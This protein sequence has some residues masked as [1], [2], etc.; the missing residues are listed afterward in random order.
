MLCVTLLSALLFPPLNPQLPWFL[1][2]KGLE[3]F[4]DTFFGLGA[5]APNC[6]PQV[7]STP[8]LKVAVQD[9]KKVQTKPALT[10]T[11]FQGSVR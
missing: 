3:F 1:K 2:E 10:G 6:I 5:E 7:P 8:H 4:M 9:K 11:Q